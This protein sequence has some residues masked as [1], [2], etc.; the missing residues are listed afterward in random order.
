M[1]RQTSA[2]NEASPTER[3]KDAQDAMYLYEFI[4]N[5]ATPLTG[6]IFQSNGY[7]ACRKAFDH[8][9]HSVKKDLS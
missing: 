7:L 4:Q 8:R 1:P 2:V 5:L 3:R 6:L 9:G